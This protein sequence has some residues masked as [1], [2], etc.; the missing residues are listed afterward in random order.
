M[1]WSKNCARWLYRLEQNYAWDSQHQISEDLVF[2]DKAGKVRL[3]FEQSGLIT[4]TRGY[5][6]NGCSPKFCFFDILLGTPEGVVH[7]STGHPKTYY[8][9]LVH[10]AMYQF[11]GDGLP[12]KR[13]HADR[14]F[15]EL[16]SA[17]EFAPRWLYWFMVRIC[18]YLI[19]RST[20]AYRANRGD[21]EKVADLLAADTQASRNGRAV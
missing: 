17:S 20:K 2:R 21:K 18:G 4:V 14:F 6:W 15:L 10:D 12:V 1:M 5:A 13:H 19:W 16:L 9:S 7:A 11:L 3:V 8:A